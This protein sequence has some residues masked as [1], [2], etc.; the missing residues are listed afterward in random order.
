MLFSTLIYSTFSLPLDGK[1]TILISGKPVPYQ[2]YDGYVIARDMIV[3][4]VQP[5]TQDIE[6][7]SPFK[8]MN[9]AKVKRA[10]SLGNPWPNGVVKYRISD[11]SKEKQI[12]GAM[13]QWTEGAKSVGVNLTFRQA[14]PNEPDFIDFVPGQGCVSFIGHTGKRQPI[15]LAPNCLQPE[16]VHEIGHAL[17][18]IHEQQ[19]VD[20]DQAITILSQNIQDGFEDQ[21]DVQTNAK[22][23]TTYDVDSIMQYDSK[24]FTKGRGLNSIVTKQG[25]EIR[26]PKG[27]SQGDLAGLARLYGVQPAPKR[28]GN[29]VTTPSSP[30]VNPNGNGTNNGKPNGAAPKR[31]R[32]QFFQ[33]NGRLFAQGCDFFGNDIAF[34]KTA[35]S[36]C[37]QQCRK[38]TA[39]DHYTWTDGTCWLK[40]SNG[41]P[42]LRAKL[43]PGAECG[44]LIK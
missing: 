1:N 2:I 32:L 42:R 20:R 34:G 33:E 4:Q 44:F 25:K 27:P 11:P 8:E 13:K 14:Q 18:F 35:Q 15:M 24:T 5:L 16:T 7:V 29:Q 19:R 9:T 41:A 39:C 12:L 36:D 30:S 3:G 10:A 38:M 21:F 17:G 37:A 31:K 6:L 22:L 23:L 43:L 26:R 40:S 28:A